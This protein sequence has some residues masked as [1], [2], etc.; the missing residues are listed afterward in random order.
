MSP[1]DLR[2]FVDC[3]NT[4]KYV[5]HASAKV[6]A[7]NHIARPAKKAVNKAVKKTVKKAARRQ[8]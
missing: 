7:R 8:K 3:L 4:P 2:D 1:A 5:S 6:T